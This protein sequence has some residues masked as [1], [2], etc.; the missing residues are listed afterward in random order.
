MQGKSHRLALHLLKNL[1]YYKNDNFLA[2]DMMTDAY[3]GL[4]DM[5]RYYEARSDLYYQLA[6]YPKAIDDINMALNELDNTDQLEN[7]R[8]EAKKKALQ[9]EFSRLKK[10]N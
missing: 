8:L 4:N 5:A 7:R 3:K 10:L 6:N 1:L 9:T 2:Y